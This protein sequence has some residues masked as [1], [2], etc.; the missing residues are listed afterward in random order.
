MLS[1]TASSNTDSYDVYFGT[2]SPPAYVGNTTGTSFVRSGLSYST[3]YYWKVVAKNSCGNSTSTSILSFTTGAAPCLTPGSPSNLS[4]SNGGTGVSTSPTLSWTASSNTDSYDVYFGTSSPP[5][6]VGNTTGTSFARSGL[7]YST[8]YYWKVVA[9][10]SCGNSTSTSILSFTTGAAPCPTPGT[11]LNSSPSNGGTGVSTSPTLSWSAS[12]NTDSYDVY[13]GTS[14]PPAYV[15]NTTGT[16]FARSGLSY[17]TPYYWKV[18]AKNSCGNSAPTS[19]LSFTT[20]A[21]PCPTPGTPSN[22]SPSNGG[23]GAS[24]SPTLSWTAGSNA[25]SYDVYFG[26]SSN[27]PLVGNTTGTSYARS[28]LSYSTLYYWKVMA[29]N[30]CGS[31]SGSIWSFTTTGAT[32]M[33]VLQPNGGEILPAGSS[34]TISWGASSQASKF[35]LQYSVDNGT[36]W[37]LI[38]SDVTGASYVWQ[39]PVLKNTQLRCRVKVIGYDSKGVKAGEDRSDSTFT[40]QGVRVTSPTAGLSLT[41]GVTGT[42]TW[43][44]IGTLGA[45]QDTLIYYSKNGGTSWSLI[46]TVP[47]NL[48]SYSWSV[49]ATSTAKSTCKVKVVLRDSKKIILTTDVSAGFFAIQPSVQ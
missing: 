5:A 41:S 43:E 42:I 14:S 25:T 24:T 22:S 46:A 6:Y 3:P 17:S 15:G 10:N 13:F 39:V 11:P 23:T 30:S 48:G 27:P 32:S 31:T 33:T 40:I 26:T 35:K 21:A 28:G 44:T 1:W 18:V 47:E 37:K 4:P 38:A 9:K 45:V 36:T 16:S 2:S 34:S 7:S 49:P 20:G 29:K 8:P 12:S 19:I